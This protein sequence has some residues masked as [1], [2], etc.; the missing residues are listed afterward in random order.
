MAQTMPV[1]LERQKLEEQ[2]RL[3]SLP[4][5][6]ELLLLVQLVAVE[7]KQTGGKKKSLPAG[8]WQQHDGGLLPRPEMRR[9]PVLHNLLGRVF[10]DAVGTALAELVELQ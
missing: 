9:I 5:V 4:P 2:R 3:M 1:T 6:V 10:A 8:N 7:Q